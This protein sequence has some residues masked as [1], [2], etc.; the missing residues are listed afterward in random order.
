MW[1]IKGHQWNFTINL[2]PY[3]VQYAF[4]W[5]FLRVIYNS[6]ELRRH[7]LRETSPM[8]PFTF[9]KLSWGHRLLITSIVSMGCNY[10]SHYDDVIMSTMASQITSLT[11]VYSTFYSDADQRKHQSSASLAF[12]RGIHR[13]RWISRTKW[14]RGKC[15]HLRTSS[16]LHN[17]NGCLFKP[18]LDLGHKCVIVY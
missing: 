3:T 2:R 5:F 7:S 10:P 1:H 15:F 9:N 4:Y 13:D 14:L 17:F 6:F 11:V 16:W 12:V 18:S 8:A